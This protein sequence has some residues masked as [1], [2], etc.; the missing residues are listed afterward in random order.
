MED[1]IDVSHISR[2]EYKAHMKILQSRT[3]CPCVYCQSDCVRAS[4]RAECERYQE[5]MD[6][7]DPLR[8]K[9]KR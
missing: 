7:T 9:K 2:E 3:T 5:W 6:F 8:R 1:I 4:D